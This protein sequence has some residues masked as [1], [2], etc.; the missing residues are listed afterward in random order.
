[1][2][3]GLAA[4]TGSQAFPAPIAI[5]H[6]CVRDRVKTVQNNV[7]QLQRTAGQTVAQAHEVIGKAAAK[8]DKAQL[9]KA[10][11]LVRKAQWFW[12]MVAA[13]N[14]MGFHNPDQVLNT[15]GRSIDMAHQAIAVA[16]NA[17]GK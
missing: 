6:S 7:W 11:E 2:K 4:S 16:N 13:E 5:C 15:L 3:P 8:A 9:D 17:A 14:S 10:R 12:D 1:M